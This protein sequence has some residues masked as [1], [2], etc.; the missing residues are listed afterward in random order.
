MMAIA[1]TEFGLRTHDTVIMSRCFGRNGM[2]ARQRRLFGFL[3]SLAALP[4]RSPLRPPAR[5]MGGGTSYPSSTG[6]DDGL[7]EGTPST[8]YAS[9]RSGFPRV[10]VHRSGRRPES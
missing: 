5:R 9:D 10:A 2:D 7:R 4:A 6:E 1:T 3:T 8:G